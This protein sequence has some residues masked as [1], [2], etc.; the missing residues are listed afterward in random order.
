MRDRGMEIEIV[1]R[2]VDF[3]DHT[4]LC[5]RAASES[6]AGEVRLRASRRHR[7]RS[8]TKA[9]LRSADA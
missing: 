2:D 4:A 6:F 7:G 1:W 9:R 8:E 5:V 3:E